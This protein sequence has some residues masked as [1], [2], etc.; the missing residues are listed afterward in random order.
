MH[1]LLSG[2]IFVISENMRFAIA[3]L[4]TSCSTAAILIGREP[5][6]T[7]RIRFFFLLLKF[8]AKLAI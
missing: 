3:G 1:L 5:V 7:S 2:F 4:S 8:S 6:R